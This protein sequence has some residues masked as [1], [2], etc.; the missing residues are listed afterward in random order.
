MKTLLLAAAL[1]PSFAWAQICP[2]RL[3]PF[4]TESWTK[5]TS[6]TAS[7][8]TELKALEDYAFTLT[9]TDAQR[10]GVRT[11][12]L[13]I[14][15]SGKI[16]YERYGRGFDETKRHISWSVAKSITSALTGVAAK[17]GVIKTS[18][19]IC[20]YLKGARQD[21][22]PITVQNLLEFGSGMH[23]Q[24]AYEN[25]SYQYSSVISMLFGEGHRDMTSFI[26]SHRKAHE[27]GTFFNYS[28]G[29]ADLLAEVVRQAAEPTLGKD[30]MWTEFFDRIGMKSAVVQADLKGMP[31]GGSHV[32]ATARD[33]AKFGY[34][35]LNDGCWNG[36]RLL[37]DNWV[38]NS[39]T[40]SQTYLTGG[41]TDEEP[42]AN[43]WMW[44]LN[45]N[46]PKFTEKPWPDAPDDAYT[47]I[48]HWG[49]WVV[50]V[51]SRDAVI[52]RLGDDRDADGMS[53]K[54]LIPLALA[55]VP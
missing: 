39:K 9:G 34:L 41:G 29:E 54:K 7:R 32:F 53:T 16:V 22:C 36:E 17:K 12:A 45:S 24:E 19:S 48:G 44:W 13:V 30:W 42:T 37:P 28:T 8:T 27:P 52:V 38:K 47:A 26:L 18:D 15:K 25:Q 11:D 23:W 33:F 5:D 31:E 3:S 40:P 49:Q 50:V 55:V 14:I 4:P 2:V 10:K 20:T 6:V 21:L 43:G 35:F 46:L 1:V 51:P